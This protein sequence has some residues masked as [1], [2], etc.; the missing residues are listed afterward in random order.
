M[1]IVKDNVLVDLFITAD[2]NILLHDEDGDETLLNYQDIIQ[3]RRQD[4][5]TL[6]DFYSHDENAPTMTVC[7]KETPD[8]VNA[9]IKKASD[10][11]QS[12]YDDY[13]IVSVKDKQII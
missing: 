12:I 10:I 5:K 11:Y 1:E 8:E 6:V 9:Y 7:V 3:V 13:Q 2:I 4:G